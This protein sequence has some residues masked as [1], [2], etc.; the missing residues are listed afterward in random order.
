MLKRLLRQFYTRFILPKSTDPDSK[1]HEFILNVILN[2]IGLA[3]IIGLVAT[4]A[5]VYTKHDSLKIE[6]ILPIA[7]FT[8]IVGL[9]IW[10]SRKGR[11]FPV[12]IALVSV[13]LLV[14]TYLLILWSFLLPSV[15]VTFVIA[16]VFAG[17]L[18]QAR[19]ALITSSLAIII[20]L[21]IGLAQSES[22]I[23][24]YTGWLNHSLDASDVVGNAIVFGMIGLVTWLANREI[25]RALSRARDSEQ[26][27]AVERDSLE[28]KVVERTREL[29]AAQMIRVMELQ[30]LS[31]Y[32]RMGMSLLHDVANPLTSA[33][34]NIEQLQLQ[35]K[36]ELVEQI[37]N[38]V[39]HIER[40]V[41]A[42]RKQLKTE[43]EVISFSVYDELAQVVSIIRH[44]AKESKVTIKID[45]KPHVILYGDAVKFN[46]LIANLL[47]NAIEAYDDIHHT[48]RL[49]HISYGKRKGTVELTV[50]DWGKGIPSDKTTEV[51][52]P[53]FT[54]KGHT[55]HNMGI[56]LSMVK[57]YVEQEFAGTISVS[58]NSRRGTRFVVKLNNKDIHASDNHT[59]RPGVPQPEPTPRR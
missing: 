28:V 29:K 56:G 40:Y 3:S 44:R 7:I 2:G 59:K 41:Q 42:A 15:S 58:S 23:R 16:I 14:A 45:K 31:E 11:Y 39:H 32:G 47:I 36:P 34:L 13:T 35:H 55:K 52:D 50:Q 46:Q 48:K 37:S 22:I 9:L 1:R 18:F 6:L 27:L 21:G 17:V 4:I 30:R 12:A 54:T 38:S 19:A 10:Q 5:N 26:A 43:G 20:M 51:F 57:R 8:A 33:S 25:D 53:F 24:P 49:V